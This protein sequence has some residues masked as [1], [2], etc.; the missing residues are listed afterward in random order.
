MKM[1]GSKLVALGCA[2]LLAMGMVPAAAF[3]AGADAA[4][5]DGASEATA[6]ASDATELI[7][8]TYVEHE[9]IAYVRND[10]PSASSRSRSVDVLFGAQELMGVGAQAAEAAL[11]ESASSE[12]AASAR[13]RTLSDEGDASGTLVLVRNES[14]TTEELLA[15]LEDDPRVAFA[16]PNLVWDASDTG[17]SSDSAAAESAVDAA[18]Q[19][20]PAADMTA[21]QWAANNTGI[22]AGLS[23]DEAPDVDYAAWRQAAASGDWAGAAAQ[24]RAA[25]ASQEPVVVAVVDTGVD[26]RNPDLAKVLWDD[27]LDVPA[28][29]ELG[30]DAHGYS[31][32]ADQSATSTTNIGPTEGHGTHVAGIIAAAWDGEGVSGVAPNAEIMSVRIDFSLANAIRCF[33][34]I[35]IAAE[36]GVNVR[37]ANCSWTL[38]ASASRSLDAAIR[39]MGSQ[40][41][42]ALFASGNDNSDTDLTMGALA[43]LRDNPYVVCVDSIDPSGA[44]SNFSCY[45]VSSTD[46]MAPGSAILSTYLVDSPSYFGEVDDSAVLYESFDEDTRARGDSGLGSGAQQ[47]AFSYLKGEDVA[48]EVGT[49]S[50][51]LR[52]DGSAALAVAYDADATVTPAFALAASGELEGCQAIVSEPVDL[53]HL[54]ETPRY[55]SI[56]YASSDPSGQPS[57]WLF[58]RSA[59]T[60]EMTVVG[61]PSGG[62]G[63]ANTA[64]GGGYYV[65][66]EDTDFEHFQIALLC[67]NRS[68][69]LVGGQSSSQPSDA[70]IYL[71]SIGL[72]NTLL[73][74][75]YL[76]GTS[77]A[78]PVA[79]GAA[80]VIAGMHPDDSAAQLA[81]R[82]KG[83][84]KTDGR[85]DELCSTGG[86]VS[87]AGADD[88]A[89]VPMQAGVSADSNSI[90]VQG[91]FIPQDVEASIGGA[92]CAIL[93]RTEVAG[94]DGLTE[95]TLAVPVDF[96][97]G[98]EWV[99][100]KAASGRGRLYVDFGEQAGLEY[101]E[102][103]LEVPEEL[104]QWSDWQLVGFAGDVYALPR[105]TMV[106][107]NE[108]SHPF[109]M[110]YDV[111]ARTWSQVPFPLD[112]LAQLGVTSVAS[113]SAAT[114]RGSLYMQITGN[115]AADGQAGVASASYWRYSVDGAWE[116]VPIEMPEFCHLILSG[117]SSDGEH[118]YAFGGYGQFDEEP[119]PGL[120]MVQ[121][122]VG[123]IAL[124]DVDEG[125]ASVAGVTPTRRCSAQVAYR[126]G[127]FVIAGGQSSAAQSGSAMGV[128]RVAPLES[129]EVRSPADFPW[130]DVMYPAGWLEGASVDT[131][132]AVTETGKTAYAP[133][134]VAGGFML[135]GPRSDSGVA[136]VYTLASS[137][138]AALQE[139]ERNVSHAALL[140]PSAL[141]YDGM[142]YVLAATSSSPYRVFAST[143]VETVGQPGDYVA[144]GPDPDPGPGD[145][146]SDPG[147]PGD[148]A[149]DPGDGGGSD[150]ADQSAPSDANRLVSAGDE[151]AALAVCAVTALVGALACAVVAARRARR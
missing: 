36:N 107:V 92:A 29:A 115:D 139:Y 122:V 86:I 33:N 27:G 40:G 70:T 99:E 69:S 12:T 117:L 2:L 87:V 129:D 37:V 142:L 112:Q 11:G 140:N 88:P 61:D 114:Y 113:V 97:G 31:T 105:E 63:A 15:A 17:A 72:G 19:S 54:E 133:A 103:A 110:K 35:A 90:T 50:Y 75:A 9:A 24:A 124:I 106:S 95:L 78:S 52:F 16:E 10:A 26:E 104:Q 149:G 28:L 123:S 120:S 62:F 3:A 93:D 4:E 135:V 56:R 55:L 102:N 60:G 41:V 46:V 32:Y 91:Y 151:A 47:L 126:D 77:M 57:V 148:D 73:P 94:E 83:S 66:P 76:Q 79:A 53:S 82:V 21:F 85:Y 111:D 108:A 68:V 22:L 137:E 134:A 74:Y 20:A 100:L 42:I 127:E 118:L 132:G 51:E 65:L 125:V 101:F 84:V 98:E 5:G 38:G 141:A 150:P 147:D 8:G 18:G 45:G 116:H 67:T 138:G 143:A 59:D 128:D 58:V 25:M 44:K 13:A 34:Y 39:E 89:P 136:D 14:M 6:A 121:G 48:G 119:L 96:A 7:E 1:L 144:P 71:D 146:G 30:G 80:A 64:W 43:L 23:E 145:Q 131:A 49:A 81:A 130:L 109:F